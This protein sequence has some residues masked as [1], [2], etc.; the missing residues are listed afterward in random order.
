MSKKK[1]VLVTGIT[2]Q[3]G[4]AAARQLLAHQFT[5]KGLVRDKNKEAAKSAQQLGATLVEGNLE[6]IDSL[7]RALQGVDAVFAVTAAGPGIPKEQEIEQAVNIAA[8]SH[9]AG[10]SH[11]VFTSSFASNEETGVS[12]LDSKRE[13][14]KYIRGSGMPYTIL[15]PG[16]FMENF[17]NMWFQGDRISTPVKDSVKFP[18][19]SARDIGEFA[20]IALDKPNEFIGKTLPIAVEI[21]SLAEMAETFSRVLGRKIRY[22]QQPIEEVR[23]FSADLAR[24]FERYNNAQDTHTNAID[25]KLLR[26]INPSFWTLEK[27]IIETY[28]VLAPSK[29]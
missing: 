27:W 10:V 29:N 17:K 20:A 6:D 23:K 15:Q 4:G 8:L 14:E 18:M 16:G 24:M 25:I 5:V 9:D 3:Q 11:F 21:L 12:F 13:I 22:E 28:K 26:E 7:K 19:I 1:T 2:G